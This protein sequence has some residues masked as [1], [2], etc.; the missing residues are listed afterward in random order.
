MNLPYVM[1]V[2]RQ[3]Q[4]WCSTVLLLLHKPE[5]KVSS[6]ASRF[7]VSISWPLRPLDGSRGPSRADQD[8][9]GRAEAVK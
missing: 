8:R 1:S 5:Q 2:L 9:P 4:M 3:K 6:I 7:T